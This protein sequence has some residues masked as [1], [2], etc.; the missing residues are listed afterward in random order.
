M[1]TIKHH[2]RILEH[3]TGLE[4]ATHWLQINRTTDCATGAYFGGQGSAWTYNR[5]WAPDLQSGVIPITLYLP[6]LVE[7]SGFEPLW[8]D[9]KSDI[10]TAVWPLHMH[11]VLRAG[12]EPANSTLKGLRLYHFVQ[13]SIFGTT[14]G[15]RTRITRLRVLLP[16]LLEDGSVAQVAGL[17]PTNSWVKVM[18]L[19]Q[20]VYTRMSN[21]LQCGLLAQFNP[22][23][24]YAY[25]NI[26]YYICQV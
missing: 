5:C 8:T 23:N 17:E 24:G 15:N 16:S 7:R 18:W 20:F 25:Y 1:L 11:L 9:Y 12:L 14:N 3:L 13:R 21:R 6:I 4:P 22:P 10:L 26:T 19:Y 2:Y